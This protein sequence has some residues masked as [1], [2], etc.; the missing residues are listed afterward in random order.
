MNPFDTGYY[1]SDEL[2]DFG[3][4]HV[5][6]NVA[7]AKNCTI[8][9]LPNIWLGEGTRIDAF[10]SI[11]ATGPL[12]FDGR[13]HIGGH[14]H[15]VTRGGLTVGTYSGFSQGVKIYTASDDYS[16]RSMAGPCVPEEFTNYSVAAIDVGKHVIVGAGS[17]VLPGAHLGEGV[18]VGAM[19]LVTKPLDPWGVYFGTPAKRL[20]DRRRDLLALEAQLDARDHGLA[21]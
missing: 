21:A 11:I 16:G 8:I 3:F 19:S 12:V 9:G 2:R 20:K 15:L 1:T 7:I 5:G 6:E 14:C 17:V 10:C 18:T 13:N 4:A